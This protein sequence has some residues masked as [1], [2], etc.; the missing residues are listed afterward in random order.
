[1]E[2]MNLYF[3]RHGK[4]EW[5]L[6]SRYQGAGGD[7]PLLP[8][9]YTEMALVG[10]YLNPVKFKHIYASPIKRTRITAEHIK[11]EL[12]N[13]VPLSLD[14][15]LE[16]FKLGKMEGMKFEEVKEQ[17]PETFDNFRNHPD[18]YD[19]SEIGGETFP[20]LIK[21]MR[22]KVMEVAKNFND[23]DNI[24]FVSHG[25]ALNALI[26]D[27]VGVPLKDLRKRGGLANTSTTI[28]ETHDSGRTFTMKQ[29][30]ETGYLK[31][32]L[33]KSDLV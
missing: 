13:N 20:E 18:L 23:D 11:A 27:L 29:W 31:H 16:E 19:P 12:N 1:M 25:A 30:N 33:D 9:S 7:S 24:L 26:N 14:N 4:T 6:E 3:V 21:R 2:A 15:R 10:K 32:K 22:S 28:I 5:N 17:F 8:Q